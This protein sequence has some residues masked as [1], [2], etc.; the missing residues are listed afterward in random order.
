M[1]KGDL[2]Q[3]SLVLHHLGRAPAQGFSAALEGRGARVHDAVLRVVGFTL[4]QGQGE[5]A[6][7]TSGDKC[8]VE[9]FVQG[10][11]GWL[12]EEG[13]GRLLEAATGMPLRYD[14]FV[15]ID[16]ETSV[17]QEVLCGG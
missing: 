13:G 10:L 8:D 7:P 11:N 5:L 1:R 2:A 4:L 16:T 17:L 6:P 9:R 12:K 14:A 15:R 3:G